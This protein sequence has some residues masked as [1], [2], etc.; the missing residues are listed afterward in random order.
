MNNTLQQ[1][2]GAIGAALL[3]TLMNN[4]T[5]AKALE[6]TENAMATIDSSIAQS[7]QAIAEAQAQ[8]INEAM[9]HGINFSFFVST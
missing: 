9:L 8:I 2:S 7:N 1:V 4:R 5:E 6:L 3:V